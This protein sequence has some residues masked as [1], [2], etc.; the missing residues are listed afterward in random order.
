MK[1]DLCL[2]LSLQ[3]RFGQVS[4]IRGWLTHLAL[5]CAFWESSWL[6][7]RLCTKV[8]KRNISALLVLKTQLI[9]E[10]LGSCFG[11]KR[12]SSSSSSASTKRPLWDGL[13]LGRLEG[14]LALGFI[15]PD[16]T[17]GFPALLFEVIHWS[18]HLNIHKTNAS[19]S[20]MSAFSGTKWNIVLFTVP[21][22][23][24]IGNW[25]RPWWVVL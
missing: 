1:Q 24:W 13:A 20:Q 4:H 12:S 3:S 2:G 14:A 7:N 9:A 22:H 21:H 11:A 18:C 25:T 19:F 17:S 10:Y 23:R 15:P 5:L 6:N 8:L 16:L